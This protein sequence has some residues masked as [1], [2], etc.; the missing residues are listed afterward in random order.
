MR[1]IRLVHR[2]FSSSDQAFSVCSE[3]V[4]ARRTRKHIYIYACTCDAHT[5]TS[6]RVCVSYLIQPIIQRV[7][8]Q[9]SSLTK[10]CRFV[11]GVSHHSIC[12]RAMLPHKRVTFIKVQTIFE[13]SMFRE[14]ELLFT[15]RG[16]NGLLFAKKKKF[17]FK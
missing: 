8:N 11:E 6:V 9:I 13:L 3:S 4:L 1:I 7:T 12:T 15:L 17:L 5:L 2:S 16:Y 10:F 14:N